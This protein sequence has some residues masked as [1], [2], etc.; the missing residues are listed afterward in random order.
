MS[1]AKSRKPAKKAAAKS[2]A[3]SKSKAVKKA[4]SAPKS[5]AVSR[6][7]AAKKTVAPIPPGYHAVTPYIVCRGAARAIDFYKRAF[8]AKERL[9]MEG[10]D[11]SV[12]HAEI[13]IGD[14]VVMLGDEMPA[15]GATAPETIGGTAS[16]LFI[17]TKNVDQAYEKAI[18]AGGRAEMPPTD[19]FWGDRYCK[20]S[21]P[22][23][24]KWSLATHIEDLT[25]KEMAR[26]GEQAMAQQAQPMPPAEVGV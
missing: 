15:M 21:D 23:G 6:A 4:R 5:K 16:G 8:G 13:V 10:P 2:K 14:S 19:M 11:G 24:H 22:F 20:L 25:P 12:A 26:R 1:M 9:R 7:R 18:A 3:K 17:Y